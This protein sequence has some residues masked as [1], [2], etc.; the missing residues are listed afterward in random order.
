MKTICLKLFVFWATLSFVGAVTAQNLI[1]DGSFS[2]TTSITP[3][4]APP[5]PL[6]QWCSWKNEST[7]T[8]FSA[9]VA[10]G[11]GVVSFDNSGLNTW[12]AQLSQYGFALELGAQYQLRFDVKADTWRSFG[13]YLGEE[14]GNWTDLL[15]YANYYQTASPE[16]ETKTF[17]FS[18]FAVFPLHKLSFEVGGSPGTYYFDNIVLEKISPKIEII[19]SSVVPYDWSAGIDM[20][21]SD[22][23]H[24]SLANYYLKA[25][26]LKFRQNKDWS[27]NWGGIGFPSGYATQ[28][29]SNIPIP[30]GYYNISFNRLTGEYNF[31]C[32]G[33]CATPQIG[34]VGF[35]VPPYDNATDV[36]M[37]S[38]DGNLFTMDNV[39][40][41]TGELWF[42]QDGDN[43]I[44][45]G[46]DGF[47]SGTGTSSS[48]IYVNNAGNYA[49]S[50]NRLSGEYKFT[51]I[52]CPVPSVGIIGT[53]VDSWD[54][55]VD[56]NT[57]DGVNFS[58]MNYTLKDGELKFRQD[59]SWSLNWGTDWSWPSFPYGTAVRDGANIQI[60]AG[61]YN[62]YFYLNTPYTPYYV[63]E[64]ICPD[65][66]LQCNNDI[67]VTNDPGVCGAQVWYDQP[68]IINEC[69]SASVYQVAGLPSGSVFPMG[70]TVNTFYAYSSSGKTATCSF[71]VTVKDAEP[72]V[73]SKLSVDPCILWPANHKMRNVVIGYTVTD[74]CGIAATKLSVKS[75][76]PQK[77][78]GPCDESPDWIVINDHQLKLR[79]EVS[80]KGNGRIYLVTISSSDAAGNTAM[81]KVVVLVPHDI[82]HV[83]SFTVPESGELL[84]V[85]V[86]P[87]PS[88]NHFTVQVISGRNEKADVRLFDLSGKLLYSS[89]TNTNTS[90]RFGDKLSPGVY[91]L[92]VMAGNQVRQVKLVKQ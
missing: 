71:N 49:V 53:A 10:D 20:P 35:A 61:T 37:T 3:L 44:K 74:N 2:S 32:T 24:Y 19:G 45:W 6:N 72:P 26:M 51:C 81:R 87:N 47:P 30:E 18:A 65:L 25:G 84:Q 29:G 17:N 27:V 77:G 66:Q 91:M 41:I 88:N 85:H 90:L 76:E 64:L 43:S 62:I 34:I 92:T 13:V 68:T 78:T 67:N 22:D 48:S 55:D 73:I 11:A 46:G 57:N 39:A 15:D 89:Q 54:N 16:W 59:N 9:T 69:G 31:E 52:D 50:Y 23:I 28:N 5:V 83:K 86:M 14:S 4:G 7:V 42:I 75:N 80:D 40:L 60:P 58:L 12:E 38:T 56:M 79:A 63:F 82:G 36:K 33:T 8:S 70:T 1:T 21:S